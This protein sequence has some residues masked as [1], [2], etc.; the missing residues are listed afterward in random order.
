ME[1]WKNHRTPA[2]GGDGLGRVPGKALR[3]LSRKVEISNLQISF[4]YED[5]VLVCRIAAG[6]KILYA[7]PHAIKGHRDK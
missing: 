6:F 3:V 2:A 4:V 7:T 5:F 1:T